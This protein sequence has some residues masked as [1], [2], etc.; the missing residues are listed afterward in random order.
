MIPFR[1]KMVAIA[2]AVMLF[3]FVLNMVRKKKL[4]EEYSVLWVL[5]SAALI[6]LA[7]WSRLL[8]GLTRLVGAESANSVIFFF[9]FLFVLLLLLSFTIVLSRSRDESKEMAQRIALLES[10]IRDL[11]KKGPAAGPSAGR[12]RPQSSPNPDGG[13]SPQAGTKSPQVT[14]DS[15]EGN[16]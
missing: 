6:L 5:L 14:P 3:A 2:M 4:R 10:D 9:G 13:T 12:S 16:A 1:A 8:V 7:S 11:E 15:M